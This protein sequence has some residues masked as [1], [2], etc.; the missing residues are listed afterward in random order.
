M[1]HLQPRTPPFPIRYEALITQK[2][3][4]RDNLATWRGHWMFGLSD[5]PP[6]ETDGEG[7]DGFGTPVRAVLAYRSA[8]NKTVET[9]WYGSAVI[10][11]GC[12]DMTFLCCT[13][14]KFSRDVPVSLDLS[15][16][17]PSAL[18]PADPGAEPL[19]LHDD[20]HSFL[21]RKGYLQFGKVGSGGSQDDC[22][23]LDQVNNYKAI[24]FW[25]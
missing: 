15:A 4:C 10:D 5:Q 20:Q 23:R 13:W 3:Q 19:A 22:I 12:G 8:Q 11:Y 16:P 25:K 17:P 1:A 7:E 18:I 21:I 6:F 2:G 14:H 9:R 24:D